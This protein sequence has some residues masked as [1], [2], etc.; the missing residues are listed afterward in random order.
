LQAWLPAT[1]LS[2]R[3]AADAVLFLPQYAGPIALA[4]GLYWLTGVL[5]SGD[6]RSSTY[7]LDAPMFSALA[8]AA[9]KSSFCPTSAI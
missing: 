7:T 4:F 8:S 5:A 9:S 6:Y 1:G 2:P 3:R